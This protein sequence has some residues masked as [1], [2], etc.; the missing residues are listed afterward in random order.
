MAKVN[1]IAVNHNGG[2]HIRCFLEGVR[3]QTYGS[4]RT[5]VVDNG[6]T[7]GS[8]NMLESIEEIV[9]VR[10][11]ENLGY[12]R[13]NNKAL[14]YL[15]DDAQYLLLLNVDARMEPD[16]ISELVR[17]L[18]SDVGVGAV[19]PK[20]LF[21]HGFIRVDISVGGSEGALIKVIDAGIVGSTPYKVIC[22]RQVYL[23]RW[24]R[25][26]IRLYAP[27]TRGDEGSGK[28]RI[29]FLLDGFR[30]EVPLEVRVGETFIRRFAVDEDAESVEVDLTE[31][32]M[33]DQ[34]YIINNAGSSINERLEAFDVGFCEEDV[35]QYESVRDIDAFC[36]VAVL[37]R[38][39][40]VSDRLFNE[41]F[42]M[43]YEDIDLSVRIRGSGFRLVYCP[44]AIVRHYLWGGS[45]DMTGFR[46]YQS[47]RGR[48]IFILRNFPVNIRFRELGRHLLKTV[49]FLVR[50]DF[51]SFHVYMRCCVNLLFNL[52]GIYGR[53]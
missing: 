19:A 14:D 34:V 22:G 18:E 43:Y 10:N 32:I 8:P 37:M 28:L 47:V 23:P 24:V 15:D 29:R 51:D 45:G 53:P 26:G 11:D 4:L 5:I 42:F 46:L 49:K 2:E 13:G 35:G 30:G 39:D 25:G 27:I 16:C 9:L 6:S 33:R 7:D 21:M 40:A 12:A 38:R 31:E 48:L 50:G 52:W 1:I 41:A 3:S 17:V 20:T 44:K 36:G